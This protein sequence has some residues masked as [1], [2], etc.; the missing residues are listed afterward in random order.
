MKSKE[1]SDNPN[2]NFGKAIIEV[3]VYI[4]E[5]MFKHKFK[6]HMTLIPCYITIMV[7][8]LQKQLLERNIKKHMKIN[9]TVK[10]LRVAPSIRRLQPTFR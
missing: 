9:L 5:S 1:V 2:I 3:V 7:A 10:H 8:Y 6:G 4:D